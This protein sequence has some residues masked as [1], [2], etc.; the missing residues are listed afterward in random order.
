MLKNFQKVRLDSPLTKF[1]FFFN[2]RIYLIEP[3][4]DNNYKPP[5]HLSVHARLKDM[6]S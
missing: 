4:N 2:D 3:Q 5:K 6:N 1:D